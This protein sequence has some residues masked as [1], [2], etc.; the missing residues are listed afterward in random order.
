MLLF[1]FFG[2]PR[3]IPEKIHPPFDFRENS[4]SF[5]FRENPCKTPKE[6]RKTCF[7]LAPC[8]FWICSTPSLLLCHSIYISRTVNP[9]FLSQAEKHNLCLQIMIRLPDSILCFFL[10]KVGQILYPCVGWTGRKYREISRK[11]GKIPTNTEISA[12]F[13]KITEISVGR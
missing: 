8:V 4:S 12:I 2:D 7:F 9:R 11:I 13:S 10:K 3:L 6:N 5:D 1:Y